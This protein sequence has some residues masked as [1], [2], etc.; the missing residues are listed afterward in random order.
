MFYLEL[1]FMYGTRL[2]SIFFTYPYEY[3]LDP[4]L[5]FERILFFNY[6][7]FVIIQEIVYV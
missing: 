3:P 5:F 6:G 4:A 2:R 7:T 1:I